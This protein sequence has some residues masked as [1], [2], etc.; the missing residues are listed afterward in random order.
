MQGEVGLRDGT[1]WAPGVVMITGTLAIPRSM[2]GPKGGFEQR[3]IIR[4]ASG[5]V[6]EQAGSSGGKSGSRRQNGP[7]GRGGTEMTQVRT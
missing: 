6:R 1:G 3:A 5:I 7:G 2:R 4:L